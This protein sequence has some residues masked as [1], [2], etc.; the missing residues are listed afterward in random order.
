MN[1]YCKRSYF[2]YLL[3]TYTQLSTI[4][5]NMDEQSNS[6][7]LRVEPMQIYDYQR[8]VHPIPRVRRVS[9]GE[10]ESQ[11]NYD[12]SCMNRKKSDIPIPDGDPMITK[13]VHKL[14]PFTLYTIRSFSYILLYRNDDCIV[15]CLTDQCFYRQISW[16]HHQTNNDLG[17]SHITSVQALNLSSFIGLCIGDSYG[18]F[19][20]YDLSSNYPGGKVIIDHCF[21]SSSIIQIS[22]ITVNSHK[23]DRKYQDIWIFIIHQDGNISVIYLNPLLKYP[24]YPILL[25]S[26]TEHSFSRI[27]NSC[28]ASCRL[29]NASSHDYIYKAC[30]LNAKQF[31][32]SLDKEI[33][34]LLVCSH[35]KEYLFTIHK[36]TIQSI[37]ITE[38]KESSSP[39]QWWSPNLAISSLQKFAQGIYQSVSPTDEK[40][41]DHMNISLSLSQTFAYPQDG[42]RIIEGFF[43]PFNIL[44][45][46]MSSFNALPLAMPDNLGRVLL[47]DIVTGCILYIWKG[48]RNAICQWLCSSLD[49]ESPLY[50]AIYSPSRPQQCDVWKLPVDYKSSPLLP[51]L[52]KSISLKNHE[53]IIPWSCSSIEKHPFDSINE[54]TYQLLCSA[55]HK[56]LHNSHDTLLF[57][58]KNKGHVR[59]IGL[60]DIEK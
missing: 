60:K 31:E 58:D 44:D 30:I 49:S 23:N 25:D 50:L 17:H 52:I 59:H 13:N 36:L 14:F 19:K 16:I 26:S 20:L 57:L 38:S 48:Y 6:V 28:Y 4:G 27:M 43:I 40:N 11:D 41:S 10:W 42:H 18:I 1:K 51:T 46:R 15:L 7:L 5:I 12:D 8:I 3:I 9:D 2:Y 32:S 34:C 37:Q 54:D 33:G 35:K 21:H 24:S 55:N 29:S 39:S 47:F 22:S 56:V 45:Q 53:V